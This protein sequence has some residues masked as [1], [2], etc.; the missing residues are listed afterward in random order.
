MNDFP[1]MVYKAGGQEEIHGGKFATLIVN[2]EGEQ[3][4]ALADGWHLTTDDAKAVQE[5]PKQADDSAAPTRAELE[6]KAAELGITFAPN[7][8]DKKLG[9]KIAAALK[10]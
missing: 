5:A 6:Q 3:D 9:E 8:S 10:D 1:R 2:D 4:A 7:I